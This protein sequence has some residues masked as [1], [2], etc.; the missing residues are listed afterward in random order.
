MS[1]LRSTG[2]VIG[3]LILTVISIVESIVRLMIPMKYKMKSIA[4]EVAV[5]TGGG[6]GL[7]RLVALR[8]ANLGAI[9]VVWDV[10]KAGERS[11][12]FFY[13]VF[14]GNCSKLIP[15]FPTNGFV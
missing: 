2:D 7:G 15:T 4:G 1:F 13:S 6:G 9:V 14:R 11:S 5:V 3:F 12:S 8:L 10:N